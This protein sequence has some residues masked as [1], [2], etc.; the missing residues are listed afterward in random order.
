MTIPR[1]QYLFIPKRWLLENGS[2]THNSIPKLR[3]PLEHVMYGNT[4]TRRHRARDV[5]RAAERVGRL[6]QQAARPSG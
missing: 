3:I 1:P 4:Y 5:R 2:S 6:I